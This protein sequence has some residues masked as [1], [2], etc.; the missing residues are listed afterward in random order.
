MFK[1]GI[2]FECDLK[3]IKHGVWTIITIFVNGI[4]LVDNEI[5]TDLPITLI[6]LISVEFY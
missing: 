3:V 5:K 1:K 6:N 4:E 2:P